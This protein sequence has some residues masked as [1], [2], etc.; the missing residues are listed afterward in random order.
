[1]NGTSDHFLARPGLADDQHRRIGGCNLRHAVHDG[2]QAR[3]LADDGIGHVL[4][5]EPRQQRAFVGFEGLAQSCHLMQ[6]GVVRQSHT[7]RVEERLRERFVHG[8]ESCTR[9]HNHEHAKRAILTA[10]RPRDEL[11]LRHPAGSNTAASESAEPTRDRITSPA[12][13][14]RSRSV[15]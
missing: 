13:I 10:E 1:M 15:S 11:P 6:P 9:R 7:D 4:P 12:R 3:V 14:Q 2:P 8:V 5:I